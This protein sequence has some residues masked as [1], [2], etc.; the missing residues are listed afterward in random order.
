MGDNGDVTFAGYRRA[1][2]RAVAADE[3]LSQLLVLKGGNALRLVLGIGQRTSQ[4]LDYSLGSDF[5]DWAA[6]AE[7]IRKILKQEFQGLGLTVVDFRAEY[8]P[9]RVGKQVQAE[10]YHVEF[11]LATAEQL[12]AS[13][14][15][16]DLL[17]GRTE[18]VG[19][20][21]ARK[22]ELQ[23][24]KNE[25]VTGAERHSMDGHSVLVCSAQMIA[26]EKLRAL[27]QQIEGCS[28]RGRR[29][30]RPR[31]LYD[32]HETVRAR[33]IDFGSPVFH[34]LV[35]AVFAAKRVPLS[36]LRKLA[37]SRAFH[38]SGWAAVENSVP[39]GLRSY[40]YYFDF[41]IEQ[42][43]KLEPLWSIDAP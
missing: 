35:R 4:D 5:P 9:E 18:T 38:Q 24:S 7:R 22:I 32:I 3:V 43:E 36:C 42:A 12:E 25:V 29:T 39:L 10:G 8:R 28:S 11:K 34:E 14:E 37:S 1:V 17:S 13:A 30:P 40:D 16:A 19:P 26:A 21:Q 33:A 15:R 2:I 27:C 23:V 31:D 41:V 20:D 6:A